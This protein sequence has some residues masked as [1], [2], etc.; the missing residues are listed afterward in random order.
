MGRDVTL[1]I[2]KIS[3]DGRPIPSKSG[4]SYAGKILKLPVNGDVARSGSQ[5]LAFS[6]I[7]AFQLPNG[8]TIRIT[9]RGKYDRVRMMQQWRVPRMPIFYMDEADFNAQIAMLA[10]TQ[11]RQPVS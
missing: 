9:E 3:D 10:Q 6:S 11:E 7:Y 2:T 5:N 4:K 8:M 1:L